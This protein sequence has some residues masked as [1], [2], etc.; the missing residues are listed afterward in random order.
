M[1]LSSEQ[2]QALKKLIDEK[3]RE[4]SQNRF[5]C[6]PE[7]ISRVA[8]ELEELGIHQAAKSLR[9]FRDNVV[10]VLLGDGWSIEM[11]ED[12]MVTTN[13]SKDLK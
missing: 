10:N 3:A 5:N 1:R 4:R 2:R 11:I 8:L 13:Y 6:D 7:H 12:H 9:F